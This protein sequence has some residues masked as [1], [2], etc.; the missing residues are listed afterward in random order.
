MINQ[1]TSSDK[2]KAE[3]ERRL[4]SNMKKYKVIKLNSKIL[5][6]IKFRL[7]CC[8]IGGVETMHDFSIKKIKLLK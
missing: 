1:G 3:G 2:K 8:H 6:I 7:F 5:G 4:N